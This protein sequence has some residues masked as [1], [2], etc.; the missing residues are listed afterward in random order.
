LI[1]Q[2]KLG[3]QIGNSFLTVFQPTM[4]RSIKRR[5]SALFSGFDPHNVTMFA[6][7]R[8]LSVATPLRTGHPN[9]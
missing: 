8:R 2:I 5:I 6:F 3:F 1:P 4:R 9:R 7:L